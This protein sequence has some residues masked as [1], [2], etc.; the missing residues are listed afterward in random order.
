MNERDLEHA[1]KIGMP[2]ADTSG[3][4]RY[5]LGM[6]TA[7]CWF[8]DFWTLETKKLGSGNTFKVT[9]DVDRVAVGEKDLHL[10]TTEGLPEEHF[11][12]IEITQ[13]NKKFVGKTIN[14]VKEHLRSFYR[15][16]IQ[17]YL[18][19]YWN[20]EKL[21]WNDV[22]EIE[23]DLISHNGQPLRRNFNFEVNGKMVNGWAGVFLKGGR[24]KAGFSILHNNRVI[25]GWPDSYRPSSI[26]G[27][28]SNDLINQRLVGEIDLGQF[29]ISHTKD[30][31][32]FG[33]NDE[34]VLEDILSDKLSELVTIANKFR[35][36]EA[37]KRVDVNRYITS[38]GE[39]FV[40]D[41]SSVAAKRIEEEDESDEVA[42]VISETNTSLW[43][44]VIANSI[45]QNSVFINSLRIDLYLS[46][47]VNSAEQYVLYH[48]KTIDSGSHL[49]IIINTNHPYYEIINNESELITFFR[50]SIY[51][52]FCLWDISKNESPLVRSKLERFSYLKDELL[53]SPID[54]AQEDLTSF[55]G[56]T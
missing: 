16:D 56:G 7:A 12:R 17:S 47:E 33:A 34:E 13:L 42:K 48:E 26:F 50:H 11:T 41:F 40:T 43:E 45:P 24:S 4:S 23:G 14:K 35:K 54:L 52:A 51:D 19:L 1:M 29:E 27:E 10:I 21:V 46:S 15:K 53:R 49:G 3:R 9:F 5:G 36:K 31:I 39:S 8:G 30:Q 32:L 18:D 25:Q 55:L 28:Q 20:G 6:K 44:H 22:A 37:S 2:P 38:L